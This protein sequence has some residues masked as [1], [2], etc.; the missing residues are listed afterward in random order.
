MSAKYAYLSREIS[1]Y[2]TS[3]TLFWSWI[4]HGGGYF[5]WVWDLFLLQWALTCFTLTH[6]IKGS[7]CFLPLQ[8][9]LLTLWRF[10]HLWFQYGVSNF[11]FFFFQFTIGKIFGL[12]FWLLTLEPNHAYNVVV[13]S[14]PYLCVYLRFTVLMQLASFRQ[15]RAKCDGAGAVKKTQKKKGQ[16]VTQIHNAMQDQYV[17]A[18]FCPASDTELKANLEVLHGMIISVMNS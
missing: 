14:S 10:L 3:L 11:F 1:E 12:L 9:L 16:T 18:A 6:Q 4:P 17:E 13:F 2:F 5:D 15:K 8:G 7:L